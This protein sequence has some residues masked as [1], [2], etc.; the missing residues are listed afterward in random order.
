VDESNGQDVRVPWFSGLCLEGEVARQYEIERFGSQ[1]EH[2]EPT[3]AGVL[4]LDGLA[5]ITIFVGANN[6]GK[7]RLMREM[8]ANSEAA[9][10]LRMDS[11]SEQLKSEMNDFLKLLTWPQRFNPEDRSYLLNIMAAIDVFKENYRD[12]I[13]EAGDG[14]VGVNAVSLLDAIN[15]TIDPY[16]RD[17]KRIDSRFSDSGRFGGSHEEKVEK[18]RVAAG[19][20]STLSDWSRRYEDIRKSQFVWRMHDYLSLR[21][22][23]VPM[24]RGM[25]PPLASE[26]SRRQS[27]DATD[28]YEER[29]ILDYFDEL[30]NWRSFAEVEE[31]K[32]RRTQQS[33]VPVFS[34][35]PRI[36]TGLSLYHDIQKRLLAP[37]YEERKSIRDYELFLS[38]NFFQ[39]REVT[40]TPA[41]QNQEGKDNDVVHIRIGESE[42]RPIYALGDG[43]QSL[44]ICT[45]P[46]ITELQRGSLFFLEEPDLCMHPS[47]QRVF[48]KVLK[49]SCIEKGHQFFLTTHSNHLLDLLDDDDLVS[50]FSF[51]EIADRALAPTDPP[52]A[53]SGSNPQQSKPKPSFRIRPSN[54]R[55]RQTL[56]ELGVRPSATFLANA[57]IWVEG[58]SDCAYLR[59]YMEAFIHY[60]KIR[61]NEWGKNGI[62]GKS[63]AHRL[64]EYTEDRHYA[65]VEYSEANLTHFSFEDAERE[66]GQGHA[67]ANIVTKVSGLC[68][69]AI[70]I[71][72]GDITDSNK[73][74]RW[75]LFAN[76]L[77][78]RF[79][80]LPCKEIENLIPDELMR[81]QVQKDDSNIDVT[82]LT[83]IKYADYRKLKKG[84]GDYLSNFDFVEKL[85]AGKSGTLTAYRKKMWSS[86]DKGIPWLVRHEVEKDVKGFKDST[87]SQVNTGNTQSIQEAVAIPELPSYLTQDL[88]WLCVCLY[89]HIAKCN[90]DLETEEKLNEFQQFIRGRGKSSKGPI[91]D[92][93]DSKQPGVESCKP[94]ESALSNW[95]IK[96]VERNC[97]LTAFLDRTSK[98]EAIPN[99]HPEPQTQATSTAIGPTPYPAQ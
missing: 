69:K 55:D 99:P 61:G 73:G 14:W 8:F 75:K 76:Q 74:D 45:Y 22:C 23:Y 41:L 51:S 31:D 48:L 3:Q 37:T 94:A 81:R 95:P 83:E 19:V 10:C 56:L 34:E 88:I 53:D 60:L 2:Q 9:K 52:Q 59:A 47:L 85:Y 11:D 93:N 35:K 62:N 89:V 50:I 63:L 16:L 57:T 12:W 33:Q 25:R 70:V 28:C 46:I 87:G 96:D 44:I 54:L 77:D 27:I 90:Y 29:S 84:V 36:F 15:A 71:A 39:G 79:I 13:G 67:S 49:Y 66:E 1:R 38:A 86:N 80:G 78:D 30:P 21:R 65:F 72:D 97:L 24:L 68:S 20:R 32:S 98:S 26:T 42:D 43:M 5:P 92:T 58:V 17:D 40:L 4:E 7:S 91:V 82:K 6:S 18:D 64:E